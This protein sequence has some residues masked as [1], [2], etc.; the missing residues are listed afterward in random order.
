MNDKNKKT[1]KI[2]FSILKGIVIVVISFFINVSLLFYPQRSIMWLLV[3]IFQIG[4]IVFLILWNKKETKKVYWVLCAPLICIITGI[5]ILQY[6][7]YV[8][9]TPTAV[10]ENVYL[11]NYTPFTENNYLVKLDEESNFKITDNI[12]VLDGATALYPVYA[13]FVQAVYPDSDFYKSVVL[14]TGTRDAYE[15]LLEGN[16]DIIFCAAPSTSQ[17]EMFENKNIELTMVPIGKEAFVFFV[18]KENPVNNLTLEDIQGIYSG[19]LKNWKKVNGNNQRIKAF[20]RPENSGSQTMLIKT[21]GNIPIMKPK[22][23]NVSQ[24]MGT[25]INQVAVYRNFSNAIGY[26]F[27][28]FST[29]LAG[30]D[31]IKLLS[32][33]G[34]KP[35]RESIQDGSYP[36]SD[37]FYA[38]YIDKDDKNGNIENFINWILT[39]QGQALISETGYIPI[40]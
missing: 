11:F 7:I 1:F 35:S 30:N 40:K 24:G 26:S 9:N 33:N 22:R 39:D 6:S 10:K 20:Q 19:N 27:F 29:R 14:C 31:N 36:F 28:Y 15:N 13:S 2:L 8:R 18:N 23:E 3:G 17:L 38:I 25:I 21:M 37:N 32:I 12:P 16:A 5:V 34:I 4:I